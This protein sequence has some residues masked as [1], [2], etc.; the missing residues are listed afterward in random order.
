MNRH[1]RELISLSKV[2]KELDGFNPQ[3][4]KATKRV[5]EQKRVVKRKEDEIKKLLKQIDDN[6][7][8]IDVYEEKIPKCKPNRPKKDNWN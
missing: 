1:L 6:R 3:I 7:E 2:D 8:K 4:E 5:D